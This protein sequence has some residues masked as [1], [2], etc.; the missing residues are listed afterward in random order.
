MN[1]VDND[2]EMTAFPVYWIFGFLIVFGFS[3]IFLIIPGQVPASSYGEVLTPRSFPYFLASLVTFLSLTLLV[4]DLAKRRRG[5]QDVA[6]FPRQF[7]KEIGYVLI[8]FVAYILAIESLGY[9]AATL[10][11]L[12]CLMWILGVRSWW[13]M[14][15]V[16][17][18]TAL[19]L[20]FGLSVGLSVYFPRGAL[21]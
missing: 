13:R 8:S 5:G 19:V 15:L 4:V 7:F 9:F 17:M 18:S 11:A 14:V 3:L 20:Y 12:P 21:L 6:L 10:L 16:S 1:G 2:Q